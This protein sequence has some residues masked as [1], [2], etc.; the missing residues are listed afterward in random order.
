M[1]HSHSLIQDEF[2]YPF[3]S[4]ASSLFK[5]IT[6]TTGEFDFDPLFN[7][8]GDEEE[9]VPYN[10]V[11]VILWIIF[12]VLMPI[13]LMNLLV[14]SLILT[15]THNAEWSKVWDAT[16]FLSLLFMYIIVLAP[17]CVCLNI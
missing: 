10:A 12:I 13:L 15:S 2:L 9:E 14:H 6:M 5:T 4:P 16:V 11:S 3:R 7:Q 17:C 1:C 8:G